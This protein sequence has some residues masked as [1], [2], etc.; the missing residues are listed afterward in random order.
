MQ[1]NSC[2]IYSNASQKNNNQK[3]KSERLF[4]H[5]SHEYVAY[6]LKTAFT[7]WKLLRKTGIFPTLL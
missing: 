3:K 1:V 2:G 4:T 6:R 5:V 7:D